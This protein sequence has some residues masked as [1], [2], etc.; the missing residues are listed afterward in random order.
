MCVPRAIVSVLLSLSPDPS[1]TVDVIRV[2]S[3]DDQSVRIEWNHIPADE[4]NGQPYGYYVSDSH[5]YNIH[6]AQCTV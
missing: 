5:I 1:G 3:I 2:E 6:S 4:W